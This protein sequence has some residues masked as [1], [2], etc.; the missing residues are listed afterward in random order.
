M[1]G[2]VGQAVSPLTGDFA[3]QA[4]TNALLKHDLAHGTAEAHDFGRDATAGEAVFAPAAPGRRRRRRLRLRLRAQPR[5]QR[6]RPG[7]PRRPGLHR[8]AGR[9]GSPARPDP[10]RIPRQ[11]ARRPDHE[12]DRRGSRADA[13]GPRSQATAVTPL[14]DPSPQTRE[15]K[16]DGN[17]HH[18]WTAPRFST[19]TGAA[20]SRSCSATAGRSPLTPGMTSC[21]SWPRTATA[22]SPMTAVATGAPASPGT[23]TTW[24]PTPTTWPR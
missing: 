18:H 7:H 8:R 6:L 4:F 19:R 13:R 17:L 20:A 10:A 24:T 1:I 16:S 12:R 21:S 23:A 15:E 5:P 14:G 22:L 2:E 9:P 3:D 11:L